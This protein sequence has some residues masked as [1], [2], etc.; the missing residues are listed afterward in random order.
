M[1]HCMCARATIRTYSDPLPPFISER[2][3]QHSKA[4]GTV[5][6]NRE[7]KN[8]GGLKGEGLKAGGLKG[9]GFKGEGLKGEGLKDEC[10]TGGV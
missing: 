2:M 3:W 5:A 4:M 9:G 7:H 6:N 8:G 10:L 1:R